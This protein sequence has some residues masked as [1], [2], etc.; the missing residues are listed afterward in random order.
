V[1]RVGRQWCQ[2]W[3]RCRPDL[4]RLI[5]KGGRDDHHGLGL[6]WRLLSETLGT[7]LHLNRVGPGVEE[8][9]PR[10]VGTLILRVVVAEAAT[11]A[12]AATVITVVVLLLL[13]GLLRR[14]LLLLLLSGGATERGRHRWW[15]GRGVEHSGGSSGRLQP[16]YALLNFLQAE[17]VMHLMK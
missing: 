2:G 4:L 12:I 11:T 14:T 9:R 1:P 8:G 15:L 16:L 17:V 10:C 3:R 13:P 6:S 7:R 5:A